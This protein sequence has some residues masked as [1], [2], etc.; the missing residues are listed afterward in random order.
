[1]IVDRTPPEPPSFRGGLF[2]V[3]FGEPDR[4]GGAPD[5]RYTS[6]ATHFGVQW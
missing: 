3:A 6:N 1:M 4:A 2:D 5:T